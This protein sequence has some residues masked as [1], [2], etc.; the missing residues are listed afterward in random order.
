MIKYTKIKEL[1]VK[2]AYISMI[3]K[4]TIGKLRSGND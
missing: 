2:G 3:F 1:E 4:D